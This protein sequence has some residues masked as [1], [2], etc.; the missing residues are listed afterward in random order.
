M[1]QPREVLLTLPASVPHQFTRPDAGDAAR[2]APRRFGAHRCGSPRAF[3][4]H[5][6]CSSPLCTPCFDATHHAVCAW[7]RRH[8]VLALP[9]PGACF[10]T[11]L[12]RGSVAVPTPHFPRCHRRRGGGHGGTACPH[13]PRQLGRRYGSVATWNTPPSPESARPAQVR[14]CQAEGGPCIKHVSAR[15]EIMACPSEGGHRGT[16]QR[17]RSSRQHITCNPTP[18]LPVTRHCSNPK[19]G[20]VLVRSWARRVACRLV[21]SASA[22]LWCRTDAAQ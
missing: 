2:F 8:T 21:S 16:P 5:H 3:S 4:A 22:L 7:Q 20:Q 15:R 10:R 14:A 18:S 11:P 12:L 13:V 9:D 17:Q 1:V 6:P 19:C